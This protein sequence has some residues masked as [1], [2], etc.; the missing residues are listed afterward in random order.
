MGGLE[1][2]VC[3]GEDGGRK[4]VLWRGRRVRNG[5]GDGGFYRPPKVVKIWSLAGDSGGQLAMG[6]VGN[7]GEGR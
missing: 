3:E 4:S 6:A 2:E 1:S 7:G 5:S